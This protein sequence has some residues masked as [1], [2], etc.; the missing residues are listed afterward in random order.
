MAEPKMT[1]AIRLIGARALAAMA[2]FI[3][4]E[5]AVPS[6]SSIVATTTPTISPLELMIRN[7]EVLPVEYWDAS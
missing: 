4:A 6:Q 3:A 1:K 2:V 7:D 5:L